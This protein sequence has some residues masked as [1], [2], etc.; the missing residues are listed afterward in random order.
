MDATRPSPPIATPTTSLV[1]WFKRPD[2]AALAPLVA[3]FAVWQGGAEG[4]R[5]DGSTVL[6][7]VAVATAACSAHTARR[8]FGPFRIAW[9]VIAAG[10]AF[11]AAGALS[12]ART[13]DQTGLSGR[14]IPLHLGWVGLT[15]ALAAGILFLG[16]PEVGADARRKLLLDLTPTMIA[17]IVGVWLAVFGPSA[18]DAGAPWRLRAAAAIHGIGALTLLIVALAGAL[19]ASRSADRGVVR[20]LSFAAATLAIA[21]LVWLQPWM[22]GRTDRSLLAQTGFL[23]GFLAVALAAVRERKPASE[24]PADECAERVP[25]GDDR[26]QLVPHLSLLGLLLLAWGQSRYGDLQPDGTATAIVGSLAVVVFVILRQ[27]LALRQ[28]RTLRG[29]I[30]HLTEQI[31]GLIQQVGRDPLT[32]L[33]NR[34]AMI[35]RIEHE[36]AHGRAFGHPLAVVLIDVDNFKTVNDALGHQAGDRVLLAVGSILNTACRGTDVAARYAGDEFV[37]VL[38]GLN[39]TVAGQ[40]CERI[41]DDV[42]RL[43]DDLAL[44]GI[45]VTLSVGAAITHRCKRTAAQVIA[46]ADAAMYDAKEAGKDRLVVVDADTLVTPG[47]AHAETAETPADLTYLPNS[48]V[49]ARG[50]RRHRTLVERAS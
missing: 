4:T 34:R 17:L 2:L 39:E 49:R 15:A 9:T 14:F 8:N 43:A 18:I 16:V 3:L 12:F 22:G 5:G 23:I 36:L 47:T 30:G 26:F 28:A 44:G 37:L 1:S 7:L 35:G 6:A 25:A 38:P 40:V 24:L 41:V 33:L 46:I 48:V 10:C 20:T 31:D 45:R 11:W 32:G 50:E 19:R 42:R 13:A 21:D 29:E 27:G